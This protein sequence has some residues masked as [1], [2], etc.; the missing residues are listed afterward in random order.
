LI[1]IGSVLVR[2]AKRAL[3]AVIGDE[4]SQ[5]LAARHQFGLGGR[6]VVE[7]VQVMVR[8]AVDASSEGADMQGDASN[9]FNEFLRRLLFEE[10]SA[11]PALRPLLRVATVLYGLP[12]TSYVYDSANAHG[13]AMRIPRT[14]GVHQG[15]VLGAMFFAIVASRVYKHLVAIAPKESVVCG[16]SDDGHFVRPLAS[17]VAIG[18]A[19]PEGHASVGLTVTIRKNVLY[20]PL[21]VGDTFDNLPNGHIM[22][23]EYVDTGG[24]KVLGDLWVHP[25]LLETS[26]KRS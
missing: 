9:A 13:P 12:S 23:G 19:M 20:S 11:N 6:G 18:D 8:A 22:R 26:P 25:I 3:L 5:W 10:F 1:G 14:R 16:Y 7:I 24:M 15:C 2:F 21:G 17:L 4:V